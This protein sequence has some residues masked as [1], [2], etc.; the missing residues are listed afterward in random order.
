MEFKI[1][2]KCIYHNC[3]KKAIY[4]FEGQIEYCSTH[5]LNGMSK[6][7]GIC[8]YGTCGDVAIYKFPLEHPNKERR[9]VNHRRENMILVC[10]VEGC[11][12]GALKGTKIPYN[13]CIYHIF[14]HTPI[15]KEENISSD[16]DEDEEIVLIRRK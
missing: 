12:F 16:N 7:N 14:A 15:K 1:Q 9:C 3:D 6:K 8:A 2:E 4:G 11:I 5:R 13:Y 10:N